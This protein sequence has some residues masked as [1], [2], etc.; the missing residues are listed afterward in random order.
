MSDTKIRR[1]ITCTG[2][3]EVQTRTGHKGPEERE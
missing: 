3:D 1:Q 2:K